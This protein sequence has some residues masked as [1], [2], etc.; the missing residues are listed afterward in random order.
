MAHISCFFF[1][2]KVIS[3]IR[4]EGNVEKCNQHAE[5]SPR[6]SDPSSCWSVVLASFLLTFC[7]L[8]VFQIV[9]IAAMWSALFRCVGFVPM[10]KHLKTQHILVTFA[11]SW[12]YLRKHTGVQSAKHISPSVSIA[13][14]FV[15]VLYSLP[16]LTT[17]VV[18]RCIC[19]SH[20]KCLLASQRTS[21]CHLLTCISLAA[22]L[23][24]VWNLILQNY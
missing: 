17:S 24:F 3:I 11:L 14:L 20:E 2:V 21:I 16:T 5:S 4:C 12:V 1:L 9:S 19:V 15:A 22:L 18:L 13:I 6:S 7:Y 8:V 10:W 23:G